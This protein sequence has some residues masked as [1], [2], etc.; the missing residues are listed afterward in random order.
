M[1]VRSPQWGPLTQPGLPLP[2][3]F[4]SFT[5]LPPRA[6][7]C[8][9]RWREETQFILL[10]LVWRVLWQTEINSL[11]PHPTPKFLLLWF[12]NLWRQLSER[13]WQAG[14]GG[15]ERAGGCFDW[16]EGANA[17]SAATSTMT[18]TDMEE[19]PWRKK[20]GE[21]SSRMCQRWEQG[22]CGGWGLSLILK[23]FKDKNRQTSK[24]THMPKPKPRSV[25]TWGASNCPDVVTWGVPCSFVAPPGINTCR[26]FSGNF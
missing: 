25:C 8:D 11:S 16:E 18:I 24:N 2:Q 5:F 6:G 19:L 15:R 1:W 13:G 7:C 14:A 17:S 10:Y 22:M 20:R 23:T 12:V 3:P 21:K 9:H 26:R 4:F